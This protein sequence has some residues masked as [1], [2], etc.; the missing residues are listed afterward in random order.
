MF[1]SLV[2]SS[3]RSFPVAILDAVIL[4][5]PTRGNVLTCWSPRQVQAT[6][7]HEVRL[8]EQR[9]FADRVTDHG[10]RS[11]IRAEKERLCRKT[12]WS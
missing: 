10:Y 8:I 3:V 2:A 12:S 5:G 9:A 4:L 1:S 6:I 11:Y 7:R